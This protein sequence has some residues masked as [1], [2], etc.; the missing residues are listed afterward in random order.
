[1]ASSGHQKRRTPSAPP[2]ATRARGLA[3]VPSSH[4]AEMEAGWNPKRLRPTQLNPLEGSYTLKWVPWPT[5][6]GACVLT[7]CFG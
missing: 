2:I 5:N 7:D 6:S 3:W 4:T 1:M